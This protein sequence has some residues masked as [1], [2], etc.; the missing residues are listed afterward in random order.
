[1]PAGDEWGARLREIEAELLA[2]APEN[3]IEPSLTLVRAVMTYLGDVQSS[4]PVIHITGTNGKTSTGRIIDAL[5]TEF[6]LKTGRFTSP[7][8]SDIRERITLSGEPISAGRF[9]TAYEDVAPYLDLV[10]AASLAD[11]GRRLTYFETLTVMAYAV[12]A[13]A[14]VD[15][16]IVEVGLGGTWDATNVADG[17]VCVLTPIGLDHM[18]Y[19]GDTL[20][21][22]AEEKAGIIKPGSVAVSAAQDLDVAEVIEERCAEVGATL[23]VEG[24]GYAVGER[25]V[26]VGGQSLSIVTPAGTYADL[27]LPLHGAHQA[28]NAAAAVTAVEAFLG[29]SDQMLDVEVVRA[30][31]AKAT[32]PG[33]LEIVRRSPTILVDAAHNPH[34]ARALAEA[35]RESFVFTHLVGLV[36]IL[37]EKDAAGILEAL[38]PVLDHVV[39]TRSSSRRALPLAALA[40]VARDVFGDHRVSVVEALP[41]AIEQAVTMAEADGIGGAVLAT[42]S[43]V[44]VG[45]VRRLL[46]RP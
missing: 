40:D 34:G 13:D 31:L 24:T 7:H 44:T 41:D 22:I 12:F 3:V 11:G 21:E 37:K 6:G 33:R 23:L 2:R 46:G 15:V 45:E 5:L 27:F 9:V 19:L 20:V 10:D 39:V 43:V 17:Q 32:S 29:G 18:E 8:L 25:R 42:G 16:A 28:A 38:E 14:P 26:A 30:G 4:Y 36:A 1:M 35:I